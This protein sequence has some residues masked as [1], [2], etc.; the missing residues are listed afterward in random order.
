[1]YFTKHCFLYL[2]ESGDVMPVF[3][4][5]IIL[6]LTGLLVG[7]SGSGSITDD[8]DLKTPNLIVAKDGS[9]DYTS[10]TLALF[11]CKAGDLIRVMAGVYEENIRITRDGIRLV[12]A[13]PEATIVKAYDVE[14]H[15]VSVEAND[16]VVQGFTLTGGNYG[17]EQAGGFAGLIVR[18]NVVTRNNAVGVYLKGSRATVVNNVVTENNWWGIYVEPTAT[19]ATVVNNIVSLNVDEALSF[20]AEGGHKVEYNCFWQ[21]KGVNDGGAV[22][23]SNIMVDPGFVD[24][25][26]ADFRLTINSPCR[27]KGQNGLDV[28]AYPGISV[29]SGLK[30]AVSP[31]TK[32]KHEFL[33]HE[34][35]VRSVAISYDAKKL[36]TGDEFGVIKIWN[37]DTGFLEKT[38]AE[39]HGSF[40][41]GLAFTPDGRKFVSAGSDGSAKVWLIKT[42]EILHHLEGHSDLIV[43]VA[44]SPDGRVVATGSFD[45]T[46]RIWDVFTGQVITTLYGHDD[47]VWS[48]AFSADGKLLASGD[49]NDRIVVWD[50]MTWASMK[51]L[52]NDSDYNWIDDLVFDRSGKRLYAAGYDHKI[53][54]WDVESELISR[55][56]AGHDDHVWSL[57]LSPGGDALIS[58][59][60]DGTIRF[61]DLKTGLGVLEMVVADAPVFGLR[62]SGSG[63]V[64]VAGADDAKASAWHVSGLKKGKQSAPNIPVSDLRLDVSFSDEAGNDNDAI[65]DSEESVVQ[66]K[67]KNKGKG[68][69]F[70][71]RLN[72][73]QVD[74]AGLAVVGEGPFDLGAIPAGESRELMIP[75]LG[76]ESLNGKPLKLRFEV[77]DINK[78]SVAKRNLKIATRKSVP[79]NLSVTDF[80]VDDDRKGDSYGNDDGTV[81]PNE[82][83]ELSLKIQNSGAGVADRVT[84]ALRSNDPNVIIKD[85]FTKLGSLEPGDTKRINFLIAVNK[86][87]NTDKLDL[88]VRMTEIRPKL[89]RNQALAVPAVRQGED[90]S[91]LT[92][93]KIIGNYTEPDIQIK[94]LPTYLT[95]DLKNPNK[96]K[97]R[98][99]DVAE[100]E[101]PEKDKIRDR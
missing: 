2:F 26:S 92:E 16:V 12:G 85:G 31:F 96:I 10:I 63:S 15:V 30:P 77:F 41:N 72:L 34:G 86:R 17:I 54:E 78:E 18:Q 64:L 70:G 32:L 3:R 88:E 59:G 24:R 33:G 71:V 37:L 7:C 68:T 40:V 21:N 66:V 11:N 97:P 79:S 52:T 58:S 27:G 91:P 98:V 19:H 38:I 83:I 1:M 60:A 42:G 43:P 47:S 57:E 65:D 14:S 62:I 50:A 25:E 87:L 95:V 69:A 94:S 61:W 9:G 39:A 82:Q 28:G 74:D 81:Q 89:A 29:D 56:F 73:D 53:Y 84:V 48:L 75:V 100:I 4:L 6:V 67:I 46:I 23:E 76:T 8:G 80:R 45:Q 49:S 36:V 35:K 101:L 90:V 99:E 5:R 22:S 20:D 44:V 13:G 51:V 93:F 55:T